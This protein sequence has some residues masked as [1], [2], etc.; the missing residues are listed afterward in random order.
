MILLRHPGTTAQH[1]VLQVACSAT[2]TAPTT[3]R[4]GAPAAVSNSDLRFSYIAY[5]FQ[6]N[7]FRGNGLR[8]G[9]DARQWL[10]SAACRAASP[11]CGAHCRC[12]SIANSKGERQRP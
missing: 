7:G 2:S 12:S 4:R 5:A 8:I 11:G 10:A 9:A 3:W 1:K 6:T